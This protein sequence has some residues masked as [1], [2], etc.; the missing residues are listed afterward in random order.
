MI[1]TKK[2]ASLH[3]STHGQVKFKWVSQ[4]SS[5]DAGLAVLTGENSFFERKWG[6]NPFTIQYDFEQAGIALESLKTYINNKHENTEPGDVAFEIA[7]KYLGPLSFDVLG[8]IHNST[9]TIAGVQAARV[10]LSEQQVLDRQEAEL[11]NIFTRTVESIEGFSAIQ[12]YLETVIQSLESDL[13]N[14]GVIAKLRDGNLSDLAEILDTGA[15]ITEGVKLANCLINKDGVVSTKFLENWA[16]FLGISMSDEE[17]AKFKGIEK[18]KNM[19]FKQLIDTKD[20]LYA[21]L[22]IHTEEVN[23]V[24]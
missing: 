1:A 4:I 10:A 19:V 21:A 12:Q 5:V 15:L 8:L 20:M 9:Q 18:Y 22:K 17:I 14:N 13:L 11:C 23:E 6:I 3:S 7:Q 24:S 2:A 16:G